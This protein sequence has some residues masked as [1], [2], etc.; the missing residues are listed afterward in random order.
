MGELELHVTNDGV[1]FSE[2]S[3]MFHYY[4]SPHV[5]RLIPDSGPTFGE[6]IVQ[7]W[8]SGFL[9]NKN[10]PDRDVRCAFGAVIDVPAEVKND[11]LIICITPKVLLPQPE[12]LEITL[13][14]KNSLQILGGG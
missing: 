1:T 13:N 7:V 3:L 9:G 8:G 12:L 5:I 10:I 14:G 4:P 11:T 2:T 6:T